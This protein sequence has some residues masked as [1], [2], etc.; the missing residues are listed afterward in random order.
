[1]T[2]ITISR[3][4]GSGGDEIAG[5]VCEILGY[6]EFDK[7]VITRAAQEAGLSEQEVI[8]YSEENYKIRGFLDRLLARSQSV[9]K[10][11]IWKEDPTG[12]R[13]TEELNLSEESAVEL[14]Q[15][16]VH[17]AYRVGNFVIIGRGGQMILK[18]QADVLHVRIEAPFEERLQHVK[19]HLK[20]TKEDFNADIDI[21]REAQDWILQK[22]AASRD[23]LQR[24]YQVDWSSPMLY[25]MVL[26]TGRLSIEQAARVIVSSVQALQAGQQRTEPTL[27]EV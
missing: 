19:Q 3:L 12:E 24:F 15:K 20:R 11:R 14:V 26:N 2:I 27:S 10:T 18:D 13:V 21:R 8:D 5:R 22:D 6:K 23:Y 17:S 25:H 9:V 4:Y 7:Q 1:M 16:A